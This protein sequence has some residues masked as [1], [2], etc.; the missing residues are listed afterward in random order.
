MTSTSTSDTHVVF[1]CHWDWCTAV[2]G[3]RDALYDHF[4]G[5]HELSLKPV[6]RR[7]AAAMEAAEIGRTAVT[8]D[9]MRAYILESRLK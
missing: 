3:T 7:E 4:V 6:T 8:D 2:L 1:P 9:Y 5:E